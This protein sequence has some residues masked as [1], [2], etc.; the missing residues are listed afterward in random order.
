MPRRAV[1]L[2]VFLSITVA[3]V[4]VA[5]ACIALNFEE[6]RV[7][8]ENTLNNGRTRVLLESDPVGLST[9]D[10]NLLAGCSFI[11]PAQ[12]EWSMRGLL[13]P[14][15]QRQGKAALKR[16]RITGRLFVRVLDAAGNELAE[17]RGSV[18]GEAACSQLAANGE[19]NCVNSLASDVSTGG[20]G[21]LAGMVGPSSFFLDDI[22]T[23]FQPIGPWTLAMHPLCG[24]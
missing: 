8:A 21:M 22:I 14:A 11:D 2:F 3:A 20:D 24:G 4:S 12:V 23:G 7:V 9:A 10:V 17:F 1:G 16:Y 5:Y 19:H 13:L 6:I 15:V 18:R